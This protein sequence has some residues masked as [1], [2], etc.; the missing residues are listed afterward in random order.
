MTIKDLVKALEEFQQKL[1]EHQKLWGKSLAQP[2]PDYPVR[3]TD[4]LQEQSRWLGRRLG[5]L[6]PFI[7][8]FEN[9]WIMHHPATGV[10]WNALE[11]S[12]GLDAIAQIK[13]SSMRSV[14]QRLDVIIG[15]LQAMEPD[16]SIPESLSQP[17]RPGAGIDYLVSGYL[18]H[19]HPYI[20]KGCTKLFLDGH[21]PQAVE[22]AAK[23]VLQYIR[24]K[25]GLSGDGAAL[26]ESVFSTKSPVLA[27]SDLSDQNKIN[28]QI[29]FME[30]L[31]GFI[32]GVRH[33]LA[34]T[35]GKKEE[36]QKAFEYLV[37][38]SLFCRRV[39]DASP[40]IK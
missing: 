12:V 33:P 7:E 24:D 32:K 10:R 9:N 30:M 16:D 3:N 6:R 5:A 22:E 8:R 20:V 2:I 40:E 23:A 38:A 37:L 4:E 29:G 17:I 1:L 39:D 15:R 35:H 36:A 21:Y 11:S 34:H 28:E 31:K 13:G 26:I 27:F 18:S 19:L 14:I 25:T